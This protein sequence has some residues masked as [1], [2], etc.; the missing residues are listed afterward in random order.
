MQRPAVNAAPALLIRGARR[1][2]RPVAVHQDKRVGALAVLVDGVETLFDEVDGREPAGAKIGR[3]PFNGI[4]QAKLGQGAADVASTGGLGAT[5]LAF[6][7]R[8]MMPSMVASNDSIRMGFSR[9]A[10]TAP[11]VPPQEIL[12]CT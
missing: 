6:G 5:P 10:T 1:L 8:C 7:S 9:N 11:G 3:R 4:G 12:L 2:T